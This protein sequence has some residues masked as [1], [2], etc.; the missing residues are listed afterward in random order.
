M[1]QQAI[2]LSACQ[3]SEMCITLCVQ[4]PA[5]GQLTFWRPRLTQ[6]DFTHCSTHTI[7]QGVL[8][9]R[10]VFGFKVH[11]TDARHKS[12]A[13]PASIF[14]KITI[15][16]IRARNFIKSVKGYTSCR[17]RSRDAW[18]EV[19]MSLSSFQKS[20][21]CSK[22]FREEPPKW[23]SWKSKNNLFTDNSSQTDLVSI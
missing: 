18:T 3:N 17:I 2:A 15:G 10:S 21:A 1:G 23:I 8:Y 20:R 6:Q 9:L 14:P 5:D 11:F 13:Y 4:R 12:I 7:Y 19:R 16:D 22:K